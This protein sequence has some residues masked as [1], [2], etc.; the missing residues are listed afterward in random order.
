MCPSENGAVYLWK[1]DQYPYN[2]VKTKESLNNDNY[3]F[4]KP[5]TTKEKNEVIPTTCSLFLADFA[6]DNFS[7]RILKFS[8][9]LFLKNAIILISSLGE[10][11]VLLD[12][13]FL[14]GKIF[15]LK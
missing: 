12:F 15:N 8:S 6:F 2:E 5:F 1:K 11:K 7:K 4:F 3:E 9:G 10:L 13:E 14:N